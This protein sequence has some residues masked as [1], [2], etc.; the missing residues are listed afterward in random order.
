MH[1]LPTTAAATATAIA[2]VTTA[3]T[4]PAI[5]RVFGEFVWEGY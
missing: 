2:A 5:A 1:L 4:A 3:A